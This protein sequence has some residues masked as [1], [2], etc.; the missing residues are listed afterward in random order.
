MESCIDVNL[1]H[2]VLEHGKVD[3]ATDK[4]ILLKV[5]LDLG[6]ESPSSNARETVGLEATETSKLTLDQR[7][8]AKLPMALLPAALTLAQ[9]WADHRHQ[10]QPYDHGRQLAM[11]NSEYNQTTHQDF[12]VGTGTWPLWAVK[13][14][15][16]VQTCA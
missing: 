13:V 3:G 1:G 15:E 6:S 9:S 4:S 7:G 16:R 8:I 2:V 10:S 14:M 12:L 11:C 5:Q